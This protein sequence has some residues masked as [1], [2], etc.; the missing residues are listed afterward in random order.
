MKNNNIKATPVI[1]LKITLP[2]F[3]VIV[4]GGIVLWFLFSD[5]NGSDNE[6]FTFEPP[7]ISLE[8]VVTVPWNTGSMADSVARALLEASGI[9]AEIRN[10]NG[11]GGA[12]GINAVLA[13][14]LDGENI[15]GTN[16]LS[17]I[18]SE[19]T[20]LTPTGVDEWE[21][22]FV[23]FSPS[24]LIVHENSGYRS[25]R[26]LLSA[27]EL[28]AANAGGGTPS[29]IAA[30]LFAE[31]AESENITLTHSEFPGTNP[32]INAVIQGEADFIIVP[33]ADVAAVLNFG[34]LLVLDEMS[35][36]GEWYGF[37]LPKGTD[38][39]ILHYYDELFETAAQSGFFASFAEENG[40][41][42]LQPDRTADTETAANTAEMI[43]R[44][45]RD[46]GSAD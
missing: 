15:L 24:V 14:P 12:I 20:G 31:N 38:R 33:K 40:L 17:V 16:L 19:L 36:F 26:A 25:L 8:P 13:A 32:A 4:I 42:L 30:H 22:W 28:T 23:A 10:I 35:D 37:M 6:I 39:E 46:S 44:V 27:R 34:G 7:P 29:Y 9:N 18:I 45:L 21:F 3:A 43:E 1:P 11:S 41:I 2:L 5:R